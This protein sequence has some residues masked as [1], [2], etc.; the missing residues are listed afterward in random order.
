MTTGNDPE[1]VAAQ[2]LP[3]EPVCPVVA[4]GASAGGLA[5][6]EAFFSGLNDGS[7]PDTAFVLVQHLASNHPSLLPDLLQRYTTLPVQEAQDGIAVQAHH[8]YTIPPGFSLEIQHGVLRLLEPTLEHG[9]RRPIDQF[10]C[11]LAKDQGSQA[12]AIVLS[13]TGSDGTVGVRAIKA[14]GGTVLVQSVQSSEFDGMPSSAIA[15]GV[16]DHVA[17]PADMA[18]L[19]HTTQS[20]ALQPLPATSPERSPLNPE[21]LQAIFALLHSQTG[22]DFSQYKPGTTSRRIERRMAL[23]HMTAIDDYVKTLRQTPAEVQALFQDFLIGVTRF[24]RDT[25]AFETFSAQVQDMLLQNP[26]DSNVLRV[27]VAGCSTGEEAYSLAI[28]LAELKETQQKSFSVQIFATDV[29]SRAIN[30]ARAGLYPMSISAD[31]SAQRLARYFTLE[32]YGKGYRIHKAVR[33]MVIFSEHDLLRDPPFSRLDILSCRNVLIYLGGELQRKLLPLFHFA[34]KPG[35]LLLL[36]N[37]EGVGDA[38]DLFTSV[39]RKVKLYRRLS[40]AGNG[41][42]LKSLQSFPTLLP[43][44]FAPDAATTHTSSP[45]KTPVTYSLRQLTEQALLHHLAV[46]A[47]LVTPQGDILYV[48][49]QVGVYLR[50]PPGEPGVSNAIRM[51]P[52][53]LQA[54]LASALQQA[55]DTNQT[56]LRTQLVVHFNAQLSPVNLKVVP[57]H[58]EAPAI[59]RARADTEGAETPMYLIILEDARQDSPTV[60][61]NAESTKSGTTPPSGQQEHIQKL[62]AELRAKDE[63]FQRNYEALETYKEEMQSVNEELQSAN[64]EMETS[65]EEMQ[66]LNEELATTNN[67]LQA[68]V[69]SLARANN[70]MRN[71][72]SGNGIAM[73]FLDVQLRIMRF[74]PEASALINLIDS[75]VGRPIAHQVANLVGYDRLVADAQS[76]LNTLAPVE[77]LVRTANGHW[78]NLRMRPYRT[79]ENEMEGVVITFEDVT[80]LRKMQDDLL[81]ANAAMSRLG[82]VLQD[83]QDAITVQDLD[84]KTLAW[85]PGAEHLYGWTE[86]QAL[87]MPVSARIPP[88][89]ASDALAKLVQLSNAEV[90]APYAD[91]RLCSDGRTVNVWITSTAL[92]KKDGTVYAVATTERLRKS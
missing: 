77:T 44:G 83:A 13:G 76:V 87:G 60:G 80:A 8:V 72:L 22:H 5:A 34:L 74:T 84:G 66:S 47:V 18:A 3:Q 75:D 35:G 67:E 9:M 30:I 50:I 2:L 39:D 36:G 42:R 17:D 70:D 86:A 29:D 10:F 14:A 21:A 33:N 59:T 71:L 27:W 62:E 23:H 82:V 25:E 57:L 12:V 85:N 63:D 16:V 69:Q 24:F 88:G 58:S 48:H 31:V 79:L 7:E 26:P 56:A 11:S 49:G 65:K 81:R 40:V 37:S 19:L 1:A 46:A 64:E 61:L 55:R 92:A 51:A 15:T 45:G 78:F 43:S 20:P 89:H 90:L 68:K 6:F 32:P 38:F 53:G 73:V 54:E 41:R 52:L 91:Q 28:V 4:I